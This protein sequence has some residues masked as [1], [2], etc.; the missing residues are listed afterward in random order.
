MQKA[1][2]VEH[3]IAVSVRRYSVMICLLVFGV[4]GS[5][6]MFWLVH[7]W[8]QSNQRSEFESWAKTYTNA[9][10]NTLNEY[11]GALLFLG[12][13]FKNSTLVTRQEFNNFVKSVLP[14]YPGIQA[15]GWNPLVKDHER[16]V[17]ESA[18]RKAG[19]DDF[20]FTERTEDNKLVKAARRKEYVIV[21]FIYPLEG[22]KPAL[23]FDI[24]SNKTRLKAITK[25]F[26]I[27]AAGL[28]VIA[29]LAAYAEIVGIESVNLMNPFVLTGAL[30]GS[31]MPP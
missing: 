18:A 25:G 31:F 3:H 29:L 9:V 24:A 12:D 2:E 28:T 19:F 7:R 8:E 11:V 4:A 20:E 21:Y 13:F 23:G 15:F 1:N 16:D 17:F 6:V 10:E 26:A 14:R 27:G 22:N 5:F 30:V